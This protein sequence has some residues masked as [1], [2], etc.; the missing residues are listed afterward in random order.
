[1]QSDK[2]HTELLII[3][4]QD[5]DQIINLRLKHVLE[6]ATASYHITVASSFD[7]GYCVLVGPASSCQ[8]LFNSWLNFGALV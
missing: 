2:S 6:Y 1:M 4:P 7:M 8:W 3:M 5:D